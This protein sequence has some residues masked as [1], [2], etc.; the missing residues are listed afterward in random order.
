LDR[1]SERFL[2]EYGLARVYVDQKK[3]KEAKEHLDAALA[4]PTRRADTLPWAYYG[5]A[6][7]AK[8]LKDEKLLHWAVDATASADTVSP[9]PSGAAELAQR[10]LPGRGHE[11]KH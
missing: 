7:F 6:L 2:L 5:Y 8:G 10:L 1:Y 9:M 11:P 3:M 4:C